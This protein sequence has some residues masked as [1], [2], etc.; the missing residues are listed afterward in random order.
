MPLHVMKWQPELLA[1]DD[2]HTVVLN[3]GFYLTEVIAVTEVNK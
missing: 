1:D 2:T 3:T